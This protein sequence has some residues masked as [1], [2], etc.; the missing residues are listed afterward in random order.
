MTEDVKCP[1][2]GSET[3]E[4]ASQKG[5]NAGQSFH[6]CNRYPECKGKVAISEVEDVDVFLIGQE[7]IT[8]SL[9]SSVEEPTKDSKG[10]EKTVKETKSTCKACGNTWYYGKK[11]MADEASAALHNAGKSM[12]CCTGCLPALLISDKKVVELNKCPKC[13][14][15]AVT[16]ETVSHEIE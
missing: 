14:S 15:K 10:R 4:R 7:E 8:E 1:I 3:V 11:E 13:G 12:M 2:C 16:S 6:V 9:T 5:P